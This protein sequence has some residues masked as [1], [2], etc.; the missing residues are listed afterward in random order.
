LPE[1]ANFSGLETVLSVMETKSEFATWNCGEYTTLNVHVLPGVSV[2]PV[3]G[4]AFVIVAGEP[5]VLL[6]SENTVLP[7]LMAVATRFAVPVFCYGNRSA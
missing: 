1:S 2:K 4:I 7:R 6:M 5:Q 3:P